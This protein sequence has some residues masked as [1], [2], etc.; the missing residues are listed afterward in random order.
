MN[1]KDLVGAKKAP[2]TLVPPSA[3]IAIAEAMG[4]GADKYGPFNWRDQP[5]QVRTYVEA[6]LRHLYAFLDGQWA[7]EDTGISHL[8][9]AMA[10]LAI[11]NDAFALG[12][13]DDNRSTGPAADLLRAQDKSVN[14]RPI[15]QWA[16]FAEGEAEKDYYDKWYAEEL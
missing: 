11:L 14:P 16:G 5:I 1:P 4:N 6:A 15:D 2:L 7:A 3:I 12:A 13:V 8:A 10:G 9:H